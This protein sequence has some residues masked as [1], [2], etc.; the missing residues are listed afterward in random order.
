MNHLYFQEQEGV[1]VLDG[2][3]FLTKELFQKR[4]KLV[5]QTCDDLYQFLSYN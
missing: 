4:T 5:K 1:V 3:F 2:L